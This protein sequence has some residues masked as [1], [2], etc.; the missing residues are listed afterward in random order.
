MIFGC[1]LCM[2]DACG[3]IEC[4]YVLFLQDAPVKLATVI[5]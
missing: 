2:Y 5:R 1:L 3:D 4:V